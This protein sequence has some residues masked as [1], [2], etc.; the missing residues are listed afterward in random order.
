MPLVGELIGLFG[1]VAW[2]SIVI[3]IN[4]GLAHFREAAA[5]SIFEEGAGAQILAAIFENPL[6]LTELESWMLFAIGMLFATI[7]R[8]CYHLFRHLSELYQGPKEVG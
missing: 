2:L 8:R 7:T 3:I 1:V 4:L 5:I 6:G